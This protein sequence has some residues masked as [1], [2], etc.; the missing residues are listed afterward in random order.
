MPEFVLLVGG[1]RY[2]GWKSLQLTRSIEQLAHSFSVNFTD[3]WAD[4]Q[5]FVPIAAGD[6]CAITYDSKTVVTGYID[7]AGLQYDASQRSLTFS[8]RSKTGDLIDC[9]AVYKTGQW[10]KQ[11]LLQIA[12][13]LCEPFGITVTSNTDLGEPFTSFSIQTAETVFQTLDRAA[14][15]RGVMVLTNLDG[16]LYFDRVGSKT[17]ATT[18]ERGKN[19]KKCDKK[20]SWQER[21]SSYTVVT[22]APGND[23]FSG[24][25]AAALKRTSADPGVTRYRPT[26]I[27]AENEDSG[28]E[29]QK[30]ADWERNVRAGRS[31]RLSYTVQGW[32][33]ESGLWTPNTLVHVIDTDAEVNDK[34]LIVE[35]SHTRD[36]SGTLTT[37][38]LTLPQAFDVEPL[39]P[40]KKKG[41]SFW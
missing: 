4:Q 33:H 24:T 19:V 41:S 32:E 35:A 25:A 6:P 18:L 26:I 7:E 36:E 20:N 14:R 2:S 37:L 3:R 17:V 29:L 10:H 13:N 30:R 39:P 12:K 11:G 16:N 15:M 28:I 27:H 22:Q 9:A 40:K 23:N 8:G 1:K 34:L 38:A 31:K 5:E 21:F